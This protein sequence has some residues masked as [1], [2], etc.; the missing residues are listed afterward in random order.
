[1]VESTK[2]APYEKIDQ[3]RSEELENLYGES[4][5]SIHIAETRMQMKFNEDFDLY[6]PIYWPSFPLKLNFQ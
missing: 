6:Q 1:M 4:A 2:I 3:K 5:D